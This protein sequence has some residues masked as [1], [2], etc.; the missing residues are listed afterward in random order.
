LK[1]DLAATSVVATQKASFTM[2]I[3]Y[4]AAPRYAPTLSD[5][6]KS[7]VKGLAADH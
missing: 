3:G 6:V 5:V 4:A 7:E 1:Q 2:E